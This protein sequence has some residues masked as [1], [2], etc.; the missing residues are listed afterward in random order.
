MQHYD[1]DFCC[2]KCD[3]IHSLSVPKLV[4]KTEYIVSETQKKRKKK[5]QKVYVVYAQLYVLM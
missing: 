2:V 4:K 3:K 5:E 1:T